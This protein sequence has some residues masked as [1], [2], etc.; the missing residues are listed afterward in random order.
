MHLLK[1]RTAADQL[2]SYKVSKERLEAALHQQQQISTQRPAEVIPGIIDSW[3]P[4]IVQ[5]DRVEEDMQL[6]KRKLQTQ[7][8]CTK[9]AF[10]RERKRH[11]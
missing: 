3:N 7:P 2:L 11:E 9:V 6:K 5:S 4:I 10:R 1:T 8:R